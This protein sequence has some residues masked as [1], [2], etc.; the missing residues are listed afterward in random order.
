MPFKDPAKNRAYQ[1]EWK[2]E[3]PQNRQAF[4]LVRKAKEVACADCG[5]EYPY[6]VMHFDHVRGEKIANVSRL[7]RSSTL[8]SV[9]EEIAKCD[10]VCANCHA[11]RTFVRGESRGL[12]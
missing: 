6:Y 2:R 8:A 9:L 4:D 1:A 7:L 11:I 3:H 12:A 5:V 10:V